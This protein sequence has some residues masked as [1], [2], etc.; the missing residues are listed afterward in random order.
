MNNI[1][2]FNFLI[3]YDYYYNKKIFIHAVGFEPTKPKQQILSLSHL[4]ALEY[5]LYARSG[6][7]THEPEGTDLKSVAFDRSAIRANYILIFVIIIVNIIIY[8]V[9]ILVYLS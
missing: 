9:L 2:Y 6:I 4:T 3:Q 7:R 8:Y 5:V 1:I